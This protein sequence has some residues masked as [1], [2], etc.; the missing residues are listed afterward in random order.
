MLSDTDAYHE[1]CAY[2]LAHG[3]PIFIHQLVV[4]AFTA[5][6]AESF[7]P[8]GVVFSLLGLY[9]HVEHGFTGKQVQRA[10]MQ[11]A[12][13]RRTWQPIA[14]PAE[15]GAITVHEVLATPPG[16][17]RDAGIERWCASVWQACLC[18]RPF[19]AAVAERELGVAS[20]PMAR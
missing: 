6:H 5:Q 7:K 2:T 19:V 14:L 8:I 13:V 12:R 11:L 1:L 17:A 16:P 15:R 20:A 4:D 9:L 3:S 10:H 18:S